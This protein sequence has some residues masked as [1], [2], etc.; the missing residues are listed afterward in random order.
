[1]KNFLISFFALSFFV[2]S[3]IK[4]SFANALV[5]LTGNIATEGLTATSDIMSTPIG[6]IIYFLI[7]FATLMT[8]V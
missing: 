4:E 6:S 5:D 8:V 2:F 7:G 1:M 3:L